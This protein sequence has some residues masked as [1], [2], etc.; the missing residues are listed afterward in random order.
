MED[1]QTVAQMS[2]DLDGLEPYY[3]KDKKPLM[4]GDEGPVP[5]TLKLTKF[6]EPVEFAPR[7]E[8]FFEN[9]TAY[10]DFDTFDVT[11]TRA[12]VAFRYI[13]EGISVKLTFEKN[14]GTWQITEK[15]LEVQ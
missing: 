14:D 12:N 13:I 10:L 7:N 1:K 9:N 5:N 11:P 2:I 8:L 4:I 15:D 6:G 3:H